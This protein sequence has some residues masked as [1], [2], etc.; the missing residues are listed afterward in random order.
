MKTIAVI[1][2][3]R[4]LLTNEC[5][6]SLFAAAEIDNFYKILIFQKGNKE[7]QKIVEN[8]RNSFNFVVE[9][10][11]AGNATQNIN[12]NR[13]LAYS[14]AFENLYSDYLIVL[15]DDV[16][17][18]FDALFFADRVFDKY[19]DDRMFRAYNFGSG[20]K[21]NPSLYNSYSKVRYGLQGPASLLPRKSWEHFDKKV[22]E[23]K[24]KYEIFDGTFETY[25][26][27]GFV[28][29]PNN[30]RYVDNGYNGTHAL[31][32]ESTDY[33]KK[34]ES[35]WV[36]LEKIDLNVPFKR[37]ISLNWR[38]DC[39]AYKRSHDPYFYVRNFIV[40]HRERFLIGTLLK[41]YR[42]IKKLLTK[43]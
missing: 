28:I 33:F 27:S 34:L 40:F 9:V 24:S 3:D 37:N 17:I 35:S 38:I 19:C 25:I 32:Y 39:I 26:Q 36:G 31:S 18:S 21:R 20:V 4:P 10:E 16:Q 6:D 1:C 43:P 23:K 29:M 12:A 15:E 13:Y 2:F 30:S 8:H 11:R 7:V 14:I 22:L 42:T 5:L 41:V